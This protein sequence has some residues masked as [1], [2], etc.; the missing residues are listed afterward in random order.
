M[1]LE[2]DIMQKDALKQILDMKMKK[3]RSLLFDH[4]SAILQELSSTLTQLSHQRLIC[5]MHHIIKDMLNEYD[6]SFYQ[7]PIK[8]AIDKNWLWATNEIKMGEAKKEILHLHQLAKTAKPFDAY[9]LHGIAQGLSV[10]H[11]KKHAMGLIF[12]EL[13][14]LYYAKGDA[15]IITSKI[16]CYQQATKHI[17][18]PNTTWAT[19]IKG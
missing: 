8:L 13:S 14:G 1:F 5:Y 11:T 15:D 12:Y 3:K 4:D 17:N 19:F 16:A 10:T 7:V 2:G 6:L 9:L 18:C